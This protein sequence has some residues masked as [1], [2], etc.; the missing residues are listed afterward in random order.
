[1]LRKSKPQVIN[2]LLALLVLAAASTAAG[3]V[4]PGAGV[5]RVASD[6]T[7]D[8]GAQHATMVEPDAVAAGSNVVTVFQSGRFF[9]G[10]AA[11]IGFGVS[12]DAG[13]TWQSGVLPALTTAST[14]PGPFGRASDPV[15]AW[16]ELHSRWLAATLALGSSSSAVSIS[17]SA[18][19]ATWS[20][21]T[22]AVSAP[23]GGGDEGTNLDKEWLTCDNGRSSPFFGRC[24][25]VYTDFRRNG[26][27]F[28]SSSDGGVT[29]TAPI[30]I[31]VTAEVPGPQLAVRPNGQVVLVVLGEDSVE[32]RR[33]NDGG[34]TFSEP[35][36][37][38][39][40][41]V[42][43]H[44][45]RRDFLRVF[46]LPSAD[47][48]AGGTVYAVWFDCRFRPGCR[49][50]D[51]VLSRSTGGAWTRPRRIPLVPRTSRTD[52]VL[53]SIG[54][55]STTRGRLALTYYTLAPAGCALAACRL[56]AWQTTSRTSGLRWTVPRRLN[57]TPMRLTWL[58]ETVSGR[59]VGDYFGAAF[60]GG[61][62]VSVAAIARAPRAGSFDQ[63]MY[64]LSVALR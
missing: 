41:R 52:V 18:D 46:P 25:V 15:V 19:G 27:G 48:D 64:A 53:P 6:T 45:F 16:D 28:Q 5:V 4:R 24:Y 39:A 57:A 42:R 50:D 22:L 63:A 3:A 8:S 10:G 51:A 29:W 58:P 56:N 21:P 54:V 26:L 37:I 59:M 35:Q 11:V 12:R 30:T 61:R 47:A 2:V 17:T 38:A 33:S 55:D 62:A 23:L 36:R 31:R 20:A 60:A 9:D 34:V 1:V 32:A 44:P 7:A 43:N 14:P 49:A 40:L 13:R